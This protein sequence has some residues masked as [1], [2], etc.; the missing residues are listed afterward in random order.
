MSSV[1]R[2]LHLAQRDL[3]WFV[4]VYVLVPATLMLVVVLGFGATL[5]PGPLCDEGMILFMEGGCDWGLSNI[6]FYS[7]LGLLLALNFAFAACLWRR[8]VRFRGF[9]PHLA[10]LLI[11]T[12]VMRSG[13]YCDTYYSH[14][15][16]SMGQMT[17]EIAAFAVLG[18]SI[19]WRW[20]FLAGVLGG[21]AAVLWNG[22][23][24][25]AFY[26]FLAVTPHWTWAHTFLVCAVLLGSAGI[27]AFPKLAN[28][29][30][31]KRLS[32]A[33]PELA[34]AVAATP[35]AALFAVL[36]TYWVIKGPLLL[37]V[38]LLLWWG[39]R[40]APFSLMLIGCLGRALSPKAFP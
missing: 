26:A 6:F 1:F 14:P 4:R 17:L 19:L 21:A 30:T 36:P 11:Q 37:G 31:L 13:E 16:G 33:L 35:T 27:I 40:W 2:E 10:I 18:I 7:K 25:G 8:P 34:L 23:Y 20:A 3:P 12:W 9:V 15:N 38:T 24:W 32:A 22:S 29:K 5:P 28:G 39:T